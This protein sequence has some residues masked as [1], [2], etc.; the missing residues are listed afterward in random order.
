MFW[1]QVVIIPDIQTHVW[2]VDSNKNGAKKGCRF[3]TKIV[4]KRVQLNLPT[5]N[6]VSKTCQRFRTKIV[7]KRVR[8][9]VRHVNV[10]AQK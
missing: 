3:S 1:F 7:R 8:V 5:K 6:G 10:F 9:R 2:I 4:R